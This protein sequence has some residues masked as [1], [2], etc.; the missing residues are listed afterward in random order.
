MYLALLR[1]GV[2][3]VQAVARATGL[4]RSAAYDVARSL[5]VHG[6]VRE[7][8][9]RGKTV[10]AA[11][12]PESLAAHVTRRFH[13][14]QQRL[15]EFQR[16]LPELRVFQG[17]HSP[18]IRIFSGGEGLRSLF[19]DVELVG[20]EELLGVTNSAIARTP[21][22]EAQVAAAQS[23]VNTARTKIRIFYRGTRATARGWE[24]SLERQL[25][26]GDFA[27]DLWIYANR[28]A[29]V[30]FAP[31]LQVVVVENQGIADTLRALFTVGWE[32]TSEKPVSCRTTRK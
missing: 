17:N 4:S 16:R 30:T 8:V 14:A 12:D 6:L 24:T 7:V 19:R 13:D 9:R 2:M 28:V 25:E 32:H 21:A 23:L 27:G 3:S 18:R 10:L 11:E 5:K 20:A 15:E 1:D 26:S 31:S 22:D 29:F